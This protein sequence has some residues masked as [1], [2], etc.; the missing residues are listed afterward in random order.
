[1]RFPLALL[2]CAAA[3]G[4]AACGTVPAGGSG[5]APGTPGAGSSGTPRSSPVESPVQAQ[6]PSSG[7]TGQGLGSSSN[8]AGWTAVVTAAPG[9]EL[10]VTVTVRGPLTVLGGC[11]PSLTARAETTAG[12]PVPTPT[13]TPEMHCLAI[14]LEMVP[15]GTSRAFTALL[16]E[17]TRP[18][19]YV[20]LSTLDAQEPSAMPVPPVTVTT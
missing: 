10:E 7:A 12:A 15:A 6:P 9:S 2:L 14:A 19:T 16:P 13:P 17:P 4:A 18:G 5:A 3:V 11:V 1:M 8:A 20:V